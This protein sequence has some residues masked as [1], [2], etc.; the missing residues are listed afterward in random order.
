M[1]RAAVL[2]RAL[3]AA[4]VLALSPATGRVAP[5][6]FVAGLDVTRIPGV[7]RAVGRAWDARDP[8]G[9]IGHLEV[10]VLAF[11]DDDAARAALPRVLPALPE[12]LRRDASP[13]EPPRLGDQA[14][15]WAGP[16]PGRMPVAIVVVRDGPIVHAFTATT[17]SG[18]PLGALVDIARRTLGRD[19]AATP[20]APP[21][22]G[23]RPLTT[24]GLWDLLPGYADL[25]GA[26]TLYDETAW[27]AEPA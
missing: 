3:L 14:R 4:L 10:A 23:Q 15:A 11:T 19:A 2:A 13:A 20:A 24:G 8:A 26:F 6:G 9:A 22:P 16:G 25:P 7:E 27:P 17:A 18:D 12:I 21:A 5:E 1:P